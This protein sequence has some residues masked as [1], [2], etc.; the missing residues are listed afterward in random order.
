MDII[1]W[2]KTT[3][4]P[5]LDE[6][7]R[8]KFVKHQGRNFTSYVDDLICDAQS[9]G[10]FDNL[11]G[12]G[13]PLKL[14]PV[15][16]SDENAM[17]YRVL[18]NNGFAPPEIELTKEIDADRIR[19]EK[20]LARVLHLSQRLHTRRISPFS[21]EKRAFNALV[22]QTVAEYEQALRDMNSKILSLNISAPAALHRAPINVEEQVQQFR[23][24]CPLFEIA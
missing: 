6:E 5:T 21:H 2:R 19:I 13:K 8:K 10:K 7:E 9:Q 24:K 23:E 12:T 1:D 15:R 11:A 3:S 14:E 20:R 4:K 22:R 16:E 18:K 17:A